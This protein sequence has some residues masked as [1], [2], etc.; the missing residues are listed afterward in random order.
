MMRRS[1]GFMGKL[2][3]RELKAL[4]QGGETNTVELKVA[5]PRATEMAERLCGLANAQGGLVIIGV[6][7][8]THEIVGV[9]DRKIGETLD[10]ISRAVRQM[11]KP[12]LVLDPAEPEMYTIS[13]KNVVVA[14][15]R[16]SP[17]PV[18]QA[19]GIYWIRRGTHT[20]SLS[21]AELLEVANDRGLV[22]W[23]H[24]LVL[25]ASMEDIDQEKVRAFLSRRE[26]WT[27]QAS[28]FEDGERV[29]RGMGCVM[30]TS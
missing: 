29:F 6:K 7:D 20:V 25:T 11:I 4:I 1:E 24:Q 26:V 9:T 28:R 2:S 18:Y 16:P 19:H 22:D 13:G 12:E 21:L 23:E 5:A 27:R 8:A 14:T 3:E 15:V 17:G 10:V 30:T